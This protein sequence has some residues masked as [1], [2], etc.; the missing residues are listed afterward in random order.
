MQRERQESK[1][2]DV[3]A[4]CCREQICHSVHFTQSH[5]GDAGHGRGD[6]FIEIGPG[7]ALSGF[8]RKTTQEGRGHISIDTVGGPGEGAEGGWSGMETKT[9]LVT[10]GGRGIGKAIALALAA[11]EGYQVAVNYNGS[12]EAANET[13]VALCEDRKGVKAKMAY[14]CNVA[15]YAAV[16]QMMKRCREGRLRQHRCAEST[17]R[18]SP[19]TVCCCG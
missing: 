17:I 12:E 11:K 9:A 5:A 8:V 2:R 4:R 18:A 6:I 3:Q 7:H 15:D 1:T 13:V 14:R 19:K 16:E 10:G